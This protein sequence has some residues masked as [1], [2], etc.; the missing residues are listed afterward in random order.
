MGRA[1]YR[2]RRVKVPTDLFPDT[3]PRKRVNRAKTSD[4]HEVPV[5]ITIYQ[6]L[7]AVLPP[8][9]YKIWHTPNGGFRDEVEAGKLKRMGVLAGVADLI[10]M[11]LTRRLFFLEVK[12]KTGR[13]SRAQ[14][15][16]RDFCLLVGYPFAVVRSVEDARAF[17][18]ENHIQTRETK[19]EP[20]RRPV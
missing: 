15:D 9:E 13:L 12:T 7:C 20:A 11:G 17:L 3:L 10:I 16:F 6:Y 8:A 1:I 14:K 5:H 4:Q 19:L 2:R 18:L